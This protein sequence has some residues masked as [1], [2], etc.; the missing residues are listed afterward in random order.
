MRSDS[1]YRVPVIPPS[2]R[3]T[4]FSSVTLI[5]LTALM[6]TGGCS[7]SPEP[8]PTPTSLFASEEEAFAAA[9]EVYR[10]YNEA[11]NAE[12]RGES[13]ADPRDYL[14][15]LALEGDTDARN[16]LRDRG[17]TIDGDGVVASFN[18]EQ[19]VLTP[20]PRVI[21]I[22]CLDVSGTRVLDQTGQDVTPTDRAAHVA[23]RITLLAHSD[24]WAISESTAA[25]D[26][27]C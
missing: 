15:G 9:E 23:L 12:R 17:L 5:T 20:S 25:A 10:E 22:A 14:T 4:L 26:T 19:V 11:V 18:E 27:T 24:T 1:S 3:R 8:K 2:S 6:T 13:D 21:A 16:E 7:A